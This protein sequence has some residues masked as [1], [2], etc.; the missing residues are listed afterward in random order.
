[1]NDFLI[2]L[3]NMSISASILVGIVLILRLVLKDAP[4]WIFVLLWGIVAFR[5]V[6]PVT[7][8]SRASLMPEKEWVGGN[9]ADVFVE[10][11]VTV[12]PDYSVPAVSSSTDIVVENAPSVEA[13]KEETPVTFKSVL[14]YIWVT[15]IAVMLF[16][17]F[18]SYIRLYRQ[19]FDAV[20]LRDRVYQSEKVTSPFVLG[21]FRPRIYLPYSLG[22]ESAEHVIA[23]ETAHIRRRDHW[24]KPI[25]Y[26]LL[27]VHWFNP[28]MWL[29]YILLCRDIES[30][31]DEKVVRDMSEFERAD[32][33]QALLDCSVNSR[34][35][36]A[37]PLA[38]GESGVKKRI[39][40]VLNY[41]KPAIWVIII[42]LVLCIGLAVFFLTNPKSS[43]TQPQTLINKITQRDG[44]YIIDQRL[45]DIPIG[46]HTSRI[47]PAV[48]DGME[49]EFAAGQRPAYYGKGLEIYLESVSQVLS[50]ETKLLLI[51]NIEYN[52]DEN[53]GIFIS[54][55]TVTD[56]NTYLTTFSL[57][58]RTLYGT[59]TDYKE[60]LLTAGQGPEGRFS[61][62]VLKDALTH[63][64]E[65][66]S[67]TVTLNQL[68]YLKGYERKPISEEELMDD[69]HLVA[70]VT[71][72]ELEDEGVRVHTGNTF[73]A[74][75]NCADGIH[76]VGVKY[77]EKGSGW[78]LDENPINVYSKE[79]DNTSI[80]QR[81]PSVPDY[82]VSFA[83]NI[84]SA[85]FDEDRT[86][87]DTSNS[88][89]I[90]VLEKMDTGTV[91]L[92]EEIELYYMEY[93]VARGIDFDNADKKKTYPLY[94]AVY[95]T[96]EE[97]APIE[98][99]GAV[100]QEEFIYHY[101]SII[102]RSRYGSPYTALAMELYQKYMYSGESGVSATQSMEDKILDDYATATG[103]YSWFN[104]NTLGPINYENKIEINGIFYGKTPYFETFA[105]FREY[106]EGLFSKELVDFFLSGD[107][108]IDHNGKLYSCDAARGASI[109]VGYESYEVKRVS[110]TKY[111]LLVKAEIYD[112]DG[113]TVI[114]YEDFTFVYEK[115]GDR[116][117]F[118]TFPGIR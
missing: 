111:E 118:T 37:C 52:L 79:A 57:P 96:W 12:K 50:D 56:N 40:S 6:C 91:G 34:R 107:K 19:V 14:P 103:A 31:C 27:T 54:P 85:I 106:L 42:S 47:M 33:S 101:N 20:R 13:L 2:T 15:G 100:M 68:T 115:I 75:F 32:Y 7:F 48:T 108:Y 88:G 77:S 71:H 11:A 63:T 43:D 51:F 60:A 84:G 82:A 72:Y 94:F 95:N 65:S 44:Y 97:E 69:A 18:I 53:G 35:I 80:A 67:F 25:G 28:V 38:F 62:Y 104:I 64:G 110:D 55:W 76:T 1:M 10:E 45:V 26:I 114:D 30:A 90:T 9:R 16:Y 98:Y 3:V 22:E 5:L 83:S 17:A 87:G 86:F 105:E 8:E 113:I 70:S 78:I 29:A 93:V 117:V 112:T 21:F 116:W 73:E 46:I 74:Q 24:W 89:R 109:D 61:V 92:T 4:K 23:H 99:L 81:F 39:K 49:Y 36:S 102:M 58:D 41:K 66:A 59:P